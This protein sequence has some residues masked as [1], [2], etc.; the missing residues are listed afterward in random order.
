MNCQVS[1]EDQIS[2]GDQTQLCSQLQPGADSETN[3]EVPRLLTLS[4]QLLTAEN[5][6]KNFQAAYEAAKT[7]T[8]PMRFRK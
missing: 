5:E 4:A 8:I 1:T 6:R 3:V 7:Q 2:R